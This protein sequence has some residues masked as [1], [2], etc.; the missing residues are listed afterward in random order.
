VIGFMP[1]TILAAVLVVALVSWLARG[2]ADPRAHADALERYAESLVE[3]DLANR[4][5]V[6]VP[7]P[8]ARAPGPALTPAPPGPGAS[9]PAAH[10][11][12]AAV[13]LARAADEVRRVQDVALLLPERDFLLELF[14]GPVT[15][16]P[17]PVAAAAAAATVVA[18]ELGR[19]PPRALRGARFRRVLLCAKL[20]EGGAPIPSLP[21]Y[22]QTL[23]LDVASPPEFLRRLLHHELLHFIDFADDDQVLVD[24]A[25]EALNERY[26]VYGVGGRAMREPGSSRLARD[27]PGF[28]SRYAT[29]ALEEDK[30][31][32][33]SFL[34]TAPGDVAAL[35]AAD[36]VLRRKVAAIERQVGAAVPALD[37]RFF[38]AVAR[39]ER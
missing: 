17:P 28:V 22:Q 34:M 20:A 11:G 7:V 9:A 2:L 10:A 1:V 33:F 12:D 14:H 4:G 38:R 13:A 6:A 31:E 23:L 26:F 24:P 8:A 39:G 36:P 5:W 35:A 15:G 3:R 19:F 27:L 16:R 18:G 29:A 25:W 37:E 30:A 32:V 21:N